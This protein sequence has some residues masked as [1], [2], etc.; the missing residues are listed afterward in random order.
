[1][2]TPIELAF[3]CVQN[4]GRSQMA[5]AFAQRECERRGLGDRVVIHTG[6]TN[7]AAAVHDVVVDAMAEVGIDL[8]DRTP[9]AIDEATLAE[10]TVVATMGCSTLELEADPDADADVRDWALPD[11]HGEDI[12]T[13]REIRTEIESRVTDLFDEILER[14]TAGE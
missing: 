5:T 11:P 10:A 6:G 2:T 12:E 1:M 3:V 4:A 14:Q 8:S 13:V 9:K 7:P